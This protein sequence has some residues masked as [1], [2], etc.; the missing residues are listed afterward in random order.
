MKVLRCRDVESDRD[1]ETRARM[2][3]QVAGQAVEHAR[4]TQPVEM[5]PE[6]AKR[7]GQSVRDEAGRVRS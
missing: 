3:E 6:S 4:N 7:L 2:G 5:P 1:Q